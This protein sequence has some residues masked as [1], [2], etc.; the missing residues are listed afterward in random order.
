MVTKM[1][2]LCLSFFILIGSFANDF[3]SFEDAFK[4]FC[5]F[6]KIEAAITP[7]FKKTVNE[8]KAF[9]EM[10]KDEY[11]IQFGRYN[12]AAGTDIY[13][14]NFFADT[15]YFRA[16]ISI[17]CFQYINNNWVEVTDVVMPM[18]NFKDFYG[19]NSAPPKTYMN[20][21]QF[22]Y[23]LHKTDYMKMIIEPKWDGVDLKKERIF[24][25]K[26]YSA[27]Q[28]KWNKNKGKFEINKWL[29]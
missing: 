25:Q 26:K 9:I 12:N 20:T 6:K 1:T 15:S 17:G 18:L 16:G 11:L 8:K 7:E 23:E 10:T 3:E 14:F 21:V 28:L 2:T 29:R 22:R 27:L 19:P 24:D 13:V 5:S 4:S